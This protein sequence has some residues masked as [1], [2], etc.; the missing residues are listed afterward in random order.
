MPDIMLKSFQ[1]ID[2]KVH[3]IEAMTSIFLPSKEPVYSMVNPK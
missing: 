3:H 2:K 1:N